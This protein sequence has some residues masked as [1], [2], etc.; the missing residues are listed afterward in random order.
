MGACA[1]AGLIPATLKASATTKRLLKAGAV[2][3]R[4]LKARAVGKR[5]RK[6][7]TFIGTLQRESSWKRYL[8]HATGSPRKEEALSRAV[9]PERGTG[10]LWKGTRKS[11]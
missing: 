5:L 6:F 8:F 1:R 9:F 7:F 3:K 2:R 10:P 4:L 11:D